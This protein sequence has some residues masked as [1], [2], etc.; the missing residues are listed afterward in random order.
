MNLYIQKVNPGAKLPERAHP[1]DAGLDLFADHKRII[2]PESRERIRT[3]IALEIPFNHAGFIQPRSGLA[4][5][6]GITVLN[7]PGLID[8][9]YRGEI[10]VILYNSSKIQYSVEAGQKIAQLV[11]MPIVRPT[12]VISD[13]LSET[14]R[15]TGGFG[16]TD[17]NVGMP[18]KGE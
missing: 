6:S 8:S 11:I 4:L 12:L 3:G 17:F 7:S 2:Y 10:S 14:K 1:T 13:G 16:S 9:D 18:I 5:N 15:G